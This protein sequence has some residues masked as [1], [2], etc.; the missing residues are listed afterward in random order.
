LKIQEQTGI[1]VILV[2]HSIDEA[3]YLSDH[4][5]TMQKETGK[6][7]NIIDIPLERPRHPDIRV[8]LNFNELKKQLIFELRKGFSENQENDRPVIKGDKLSC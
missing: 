6:I 7:Q 2:T 8:D 3:V 5:I 1:T 4:V